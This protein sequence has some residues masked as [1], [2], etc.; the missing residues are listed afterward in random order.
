MLSKHYDEE[1][2]VS[3]FQKSTPSTVSKNLGLEWR[4]WVNLIVSILTHSQWIASRI[5]TGAT[6][7]STTGH[8]I[9]P[10]WT[11]MVM[12]GNTDVGMT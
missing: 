4:I 5:W 12:M 6:I 7:F 8:V 1:T 3:Y 9:A 2:P 10:A 11:A